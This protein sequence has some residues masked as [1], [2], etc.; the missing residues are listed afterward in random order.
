MNTPVAVSF[1]QVYARLREIARNER[2]KGGAGATLNTTALVHETYIELSTS[3]ASELPRDFYAYAA[4]AMRNLIIDEARRRMRVKRGGNVQRVDVDVDA[5]ELAI[6]DRDLAEAV[7][8]N[9]ALQHLAKEHARAAE[10]V[11]LHYFAGLDLGKIAEL[12]GVSERT[13]NRDWR[14]ARAWLKSQLG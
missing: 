12:L 7:E 13:I 6:P 9:D 4:R 1:E 14:A 11:D 5:G 10:I 8:L 3:G 2:R